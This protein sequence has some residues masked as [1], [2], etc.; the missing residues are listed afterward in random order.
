MSTSD[1]E[2][3]KKHLCTECWQRDGKWRIEYKTYM[4]ERCFIDRNLGIIKK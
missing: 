4:C 1:V 3:E 2:S